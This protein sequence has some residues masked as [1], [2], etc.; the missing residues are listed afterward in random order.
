MSA[1]LSSAA[2]Q[3]PPRVAL[4]GGLTGGHVMPCLTLALAL[5]QRACSVLYVGGA[6]QLEEAMAHRYG[7]PFAKLPFVRRPAIV[8]SGSLLPSFLGALSA[9]R[10]FRPHVVFSK[11]SA[12]SV[13]V[14]LAA[15]LLRTPVLLHESD[16]IPGLENLWMQRLAH[17]VCV[18]FVEAARYFSV[19]V[20][21]TGNLTRPNFTDGDPRVGRQ[22]Y[23][24]S[25]D[26]PLLYVTGGSQGAEPLN[27]LVYP[28]VD[29][30]TSRYAVIHQ[31]GRGKVRAPLGHRD[32][33]AVEFIHDD[34]RHLYAACDAVVSRSGASSIAEITTYRVPALYV[35][36]PWAENDHQDRNAATLEARGVCTVLRQHTLT[37]ERLLCGIDAVMAGRQIYRSRYAGLDV[38]DALAAL[39]SLILRH[40]GRGTAVDT[41]VAHPVG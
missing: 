32:Y 3:A 9:L 34:L 24:V 22:L 23:P 40:C 12:L 1:W 37:P 18:G 21:V 33:H 6:G 14:V 20:Q 10:R 29:E 39:T 26:K 13:P 16:V 11:G 35:P 17:V 5:R 28:I 36:Y 19:P 4:T 38:P 30:L 2:R 41:A 31:C 7:V 8:R 15:R 25:P 27:Q